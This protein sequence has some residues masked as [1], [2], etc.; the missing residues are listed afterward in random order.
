MNMGTPANIVAQALPRRG[1]KSGGKAEI[2]R[3]VR[4]LGEGKAS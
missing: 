4:S 3:H 1:M 2:G